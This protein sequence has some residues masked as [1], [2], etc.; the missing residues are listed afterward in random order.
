V[1]LSAGMTSQGRRRAL[2]PKL[3]LRHALGREAP[4][5][6]RG[7]PRAGS[8]DFISSAGQGVRQ[9][10]RSRRAE[11]WSRS[12]GIHGE[13]GT[14]SNILCPSNAGEK[15]P[16][17]DGMSSCVPSDTGLALVASFKTACT[18]SSP[19]M[20]TACRRLRRRLLRNSPPPERGRN[21]SLIRTGRGTPDS[22]LLM[23]SSE[24][25]PRTPP[26]GKRSFPP[27][28]VTKPELR[29]EGTNSL[30]CT[31]NEIS[32]T[33]PRTPPPGKR[34]FPPKCVPKPELRHESASAP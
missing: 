11:A 32:R 16:T 10:E 34:S 13:M 29:Y 9:P 30:H 28:C 4:L 25:C 21:P 18:S 5:P 27:K 7:C 31:A 1:I 23:T 14:I 24:A 26:P 2:V 33:S 20:A 6:R 12:R 3:R 17:H 15:P 8:G 22:A 19:R